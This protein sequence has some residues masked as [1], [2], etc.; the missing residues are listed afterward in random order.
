MN[1]KKIIHSNVMFSEAL[2]K[3]QMLQNGYSAS[4]YT[5]SYNLARNQL[6]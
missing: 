2:N 5:V 3:E 4:T 1:L 6:V